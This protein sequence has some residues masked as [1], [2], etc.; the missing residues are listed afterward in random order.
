MFLI[1]SGKYHFGKYFFLPD[2]LFSLRIVLFQ[3]QKYF[4]R[5]LR[6]FVLN[7]FIVV[8]TAVL[9]LDVC[10]QILNQRSCPV[11]DFK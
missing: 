11:Q 4:I 1:C 3:N 2:W 10:E 5:L 8:V 7:M 9:H 6:A